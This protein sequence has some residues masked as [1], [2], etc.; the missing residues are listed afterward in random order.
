MGELK[1]KDK[2]IVVP[3]DVL[4]EGMDFLPAGGAFREGENIIASQV[5]VVSVNGRLLKLVPL[6]AKYIPK[7][8]DTVIGKIVEVTNNC[9]FV[10]IGYSNHACIP[11]RDGSMEYIPKGADLTQYYDY[12]DFVVANITNVSKSKEIDLSMKGPGLR[13][14][15]EGRIIKVN[16]AK[17]PRIIGKQGSMISMIKQ[18][19]DCR[20][21]VGQNG[22]VWLYDID[23][24]KEVIAVEA[25]KKI[26]E[27]AHIQGLTDEIKMFLESKVGVK[28]AVQ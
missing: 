25:I 15:S 11:L 3:G 7:R 4:A 23:P 26:E 20:I 12:N 6:N 17:V 19:T 14:L 2:D 1:V 8:G 28:N 5:G 13:K 16:S 22:L 18:M 9:W 24:L 10:D 27:R 21:V